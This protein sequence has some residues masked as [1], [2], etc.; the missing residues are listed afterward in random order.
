MQLTLVP[1]IE[2]SPRLLTAAQTLVGRL[3]L[4]AIAWLLLVLLNYQ[5]PLPTVAAL[6]LFILWPQYRREW[7]SLATVG[8]W[9]FGF[10][11]FGEQAIAE[12][13]QLF[14]LG[15]AASAVAPLISLA[16]AVLLIGGIHALLF[17][18]PRWNIRPLAGAIILYAVLAILASYAPLA[19]PWRAVLWLFLIYWSRFFWFGAYTLHDWNRPLPGRWRQLSHA[20]PFWSPSDIPYPK[21][22]AYLQRIEAK[23]AEAAAV[24]QLKGVKL[25]YW[26]LWL[27]L[28]TALFKATFYGYG[29][30]FGGYVRLVRDQGELLLGADS[31][32]VATGIVIPQWLHVDDYF[33]TFDYCAVTACD[34]SWRNWKAIGARFIEDLLWTAVMGHVAIGIVRLAGYNALRNTVNP[35]ASRSIADFWNRYNYYFKELLVNL[36]YFPAF[37]SLRFCPPWL[38]MYLAVIFAVCFGNFLFHLVR[39][40]DSTIR[41]GVW[42]AVWEFRTFFLYT[43]ILAHGIFLSQYINERRRG[44][45]SWLER[46]IATPVIVLGFFCLATVFVDHRRGTSIESQLKFILSLFGLN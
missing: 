1:A 7:L 12:Q 30:L 22:A 29:E 13:L 25:L 34:D 9:L 17:Q 3:V 37:L 44:R 45:K 6:A 24:S 43:L 10:Q 39:G 2:R 16:L 20:L 32:A 41:Y 46:R 42:D 14:A 35:V 31:W 40:I 27:V 4:I 21:A 33:R 18:L 15:P 26:A 36:F 28:F 5:W 11:W 8:F 19:E 23:D 38:R